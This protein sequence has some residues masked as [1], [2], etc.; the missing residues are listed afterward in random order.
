MVLASRFVAGIS[1]IVPIF[2]W[3]VFSAMLTPDSSFSEIL[4]ARNYGAE[5]AGVQAKKQE[6]EAA[7]KKV[8]NEINKYQSETENIKDNK[9][10]QQVME[11][12]IDFL[13]IMLRINKIT[14]KALNLTPELNNAIRMLVFNSYSGR[15]NDDGTVSV[16]I[17]GSVRD[18]KR[19][20]I[21]KLT[22]LIETINGDEYFDGIEQRSFSK[23]EDEEGGSTTSF[24]FNIT[25]YPDAGDELSDSVG[26]PSE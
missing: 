12:R 21:S 1:L 4:N 5:L 18:P 10:L 16:S 23:S 8:Q 9:V 15:M 19:L 2:S 24:S 3:I 6:K 11:E 25:Y 20:S 17:T 26:A 7:L 22:R 14:L 13:E